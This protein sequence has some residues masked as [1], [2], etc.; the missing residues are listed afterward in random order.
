[1]KN[2]D[3]AGIIMR[4]LVSKLTQFF[5]KNKNPLQLKGMK[6]QKANGDPIHMMARLND[7]RKIYYR[8]PEKIISIYPG[9]I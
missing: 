6:S 7:L 3:F 5:Q 4:C 9:F 1:M 8:R 2:N